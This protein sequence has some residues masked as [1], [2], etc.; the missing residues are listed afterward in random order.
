MVVFYHIINKSQGK[1]AKKA[2]FSV[3]GPWYL[4]TGIE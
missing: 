1:S 4:A 2:D 3:S